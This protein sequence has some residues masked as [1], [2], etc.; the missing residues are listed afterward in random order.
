MNKFRLAVVKSFNPK[1]M[2]NPLLQAVFANSERIKNDPE[3]QR[4][5]QSVAEES[6]RR[7]MLMFAAALPVSLL[8][9][10]GLIYLFYLWPGYTIT[11][12]L[13]GMVFTA[14]V[15]LSNYLVVNLLN[16]EPK[17]YWFF[18]FLTITYVGLSV[19]SA[20]LLG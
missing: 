10:G 15:M 5:R 4:V 12:V 2:E 3:I 20:Q 14:F 13:H 16:W 1:A 17:G 7:L 11:G 6:R 9:V 8:F 19:L 18:V